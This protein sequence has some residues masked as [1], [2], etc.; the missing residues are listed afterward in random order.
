MEIIN[1][2]EA[3][4][5]MALGASIKGCAVI[6]F[7]VLAR[8]LFRERLSPA[9]TY[10]LWFLAL[11]R[12]SIWDL[13]NS[14]W[15]FFNWSAVN[16]ID[17]LLT[18]RISLETATPIF[19]ASDTSQVP[20]PSFSRSSPILIGA[21]ESTEAT[22]ETNPINSSLPNL[23]TAMPLPSQESDQPFSAGTLAGVAW[24]SGVLFFVLRFALVNFRFHQRLWHCEEIQDP[25]LHSILDKCRA[26]VGV[27]RP[28]RIIET[29]N[30][31]TP[32]VF[33]LGRIYLLIPKGQSDR[34]S[35][36]EWQ[37]LM[38]HELSHIRRYDIE[39]NIWLNLV[40]AIHWYNPVVR[41]MGHRMRIERELACDAHALAKIPTT[42]SKHYGETILKVVD[43]IPGTFP[44]TAH[45]GVL[46]N[47]RHIKERI[48][49]I[50]KFH[51]QTSVPSIAIVL[52]LGLGAVFLTEGQPSETTES[53]EPIDPIPLTAHQDHPAAQFDNRG[54]YATNDQ[55]WT[56]SHCP[57]GDQSF[58]GVPF[59][60][61]GIIRLASQ[62]ATRDSRHHRP[63]VSG[64]QVG[65]N[66]DRLYLL[67]GTHYSSPEGSLVA[68]L[69]LNYEDGSDTDI[70]ILY[71]VH[72]RDWWRHKY[73]SPINLTDPQSRVVWTGHH[74][75][76]AA[77]GK[78]LRLCLTSI[79]NPQPKKKIAT[80]D[81]ISA[82]SH[83]SELVFGISGGPANLPESWRTSP[84]ILEPEADHTQS[85]AFTA[86]DSTT[87]TPIKNL[88]LRVEGAD[89]DSHFFIG[90]FFTD[91]KGETS[92][93]FPSGPLIYLTIWADAD[94]Y[95]PMIIQW[96]T[97]NHGPFPASYNYSIA[98][99]IEIGGSIK[100]SAGAPVSGAEIRLQGPRIQ[101]NS[102]EKQ[103]LAMT[104]T[105][106]STDENG[107]WKYAGIPEDLNKFQIGIRHP[108]YRQITTSIDRQISATRT[109]SGPNSER[110]KLPL[111]RNLL[112]KQYDVQLKQ[113]PSVSGSIKD[114][115]GIPIE[116]AR[117]TVRRGRSGRTTLSDDKGTFSIKNIYFSGN[118]V[119]V[120]SPGFAPLIEVL[121][122]L[123]TL[124]NRAALHDPTQPEV[125]PSHQM[126][127]TLKTTKP[128]R[129]Q[130]I[131]ASGEAVHNVSIKVQS[132][133]TR[134]N[135][136]WLGLT[137]K[138]GMFEWNGA[139]SF[140]FILNLAH[141]EYRDISV[142]ITAPHRRTE[143]ITLQPA[144][145]MA[146]RVIN[147]T[148]GQ[149]IA[150]ARLKTGYRRRNDDKITWDENPQ[151][152]AIQGEYQIIFGR[153]P[154]S[155]L[156]LMIEA[157]GYETAI[158]KGYRKGGSV[159]EN[160]QLDALPLP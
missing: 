130:V 36:A 146:G 103:L 110:F 18:T 74:E 131:D 89:L 80:M 79:Q 31:D 109:D 78:S 111:F 5:W 75:Q 92:I 53:I 47:K 83:S 13:P 144:L 157:Q 104:K 147:A 81:L 59:R 84:K 4:F 138:E 88:H 98:P 56:W 145:I 134:R 19:V 45:I 28:I 77:Y 121:P 61:D 105:H 17:Q 2:I 41:W 148:T 51:R 155:E 14:E 102:G 3:V 58:L 33:G 151:A 34:Y 132:W 66:Y 1:H 129:G 149:A 73:E 117:V 116:S 22:I 153:D 133:N 139:L 50:A 137:D 112:K 93:K 99:G 85:I 122:T 107:D 119:L 25:A 113:L 118:P 30:V 128:F 7:I 72:V 62:E 114:Q 52:C 120:E 16:R 71:G 8:R 143:T 70:E 38:T 63:E 154:A 150:H 125:T 68:T 46:E 40:E 11:I 76:L 108:D 135:L 9:W 158:S 48:K 94:G 32:A 69:R 100:N 15:S 123:E 106:I 91:R 97:R 156:F 152:I 127:L 12:L 87:E 54:F 20:A 140:P 39:T 159:T 24:L 44:K 82:N 115:N 86:S 124:E 43:Q 57:K 90:H 49:M 26:R 65:K 96:D 35:E 29:E 6:L 141:P 27:K 160:F 60:I 64:I 37:D 55:A 67:H 136:I 95:P 10:A 142:E 21:P 126:E 42:D 101:I 23:D